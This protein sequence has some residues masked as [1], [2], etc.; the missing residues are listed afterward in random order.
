MRHTLPLSEVHKSWD[1]TQNQR[2]CGLWV[3]LRCT[4]TL[5]QEEKGRREGKKRHKE[6]AG[7]FTIRLS[8]TPQFTQVATLIPPGP[9]SWERAVD[10]PHAVP[11]VRTERQTAAAPTCPQARSPRGP[12][13]PLPDRAEQT[14]RCKGSAA[15]FT[16]VIPTPTTNT[17]RRNG[18][19]EL[20]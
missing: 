1:S 13:R 7:D 15:P 9:R 20:E 5:T 2:R 10:V 17:R 4:N 6:Q 3:I 19:R 8:P 12:S 11:I 14:A 18:V 16:L